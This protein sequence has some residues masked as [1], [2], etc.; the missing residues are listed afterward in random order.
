VNDAGCLSTDLGTPPS[1][2]HDQWSETGRSLFCPNER[3]WTTRDDDDSSCDACGADVPDLVAKA[4]CPTPSTE[5]IAEVLGEHRWPIAEPC[6]CGEQLFSYEEH[7]AHL[8]SVLAHLVR[9]GD[10]T[11][12]I[13]ERLPLLRPM[14][15]TPNQKLHHLPT[16]NPMH[17]T[18]ML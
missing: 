6:T 3:V 5:Q 9:G 7:E 12:P 13:R 17:I 10:T 4:A 2:D 11:E 8:G 16:N 18:W 14:H 15:H 1:T